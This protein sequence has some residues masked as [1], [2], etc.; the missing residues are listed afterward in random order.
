MRMYLP[1]QPS[2]LERDVSD[3][4]Y[5]YQ[6]YLPSRSLESYVACYWTVDVKASDSNKLHRILPDA[7]TDI[8]FDLRASSFSKGAFVVGLMTDFAVMNLSQT[9][10][11]FG[12]R[13]FSDAVRPFFKYPVSEF[14]G[15]H[16]FLEDIWGKEAALITEEIVSATG[17]LE[18]I[19][20]VELILIRML[21][22]NEFPTDGLLQTGMRYMYDQQGRMSIRTLAE[23]LSYSERTIRRTFQ[24]EL[25]V[26]PKELVGIIRFQSLLHELYL[27]TQSSF[28]DIAV[29]YGYYDQ[30]HFIKDFKRYYGMS[31][32]QVFTTNLGMK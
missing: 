11:L 23:K 7:C 18:I 21:L 19:E 16:V 25:G 17:V 12:I 9:E 6:E 2:I 13:F 30:P 8:I 3:S 26:S 27:T 10:S 15:N 14:I 29:K 32:N 20:K 28:T 31:P 5:R 4:N 22:L 24:K 1:I